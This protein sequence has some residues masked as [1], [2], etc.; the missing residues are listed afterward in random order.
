ALLTCR[1]ETGRTHQIRVHMAHLGC[2]CLGDPVYGSGA[3][4]KEVQAIL[5]DLDFSRQALHAGL[6]GFIHP[7]TGDKLKF[8]APL[9]DDMQELADALADMY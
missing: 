1:L 2:P 6:L 3:P 9:P 4:A 5:K 8:K 7:I